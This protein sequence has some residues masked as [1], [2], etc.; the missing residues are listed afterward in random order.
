MSFE[1]DLVFT[2]PTRRPSTYTAS[3]PVLLWRAT[4]MPTAE[5]VKRSLSEACREPDASTFPFIAPL[6]RSR[7]HLPDRFTLLLLSS[8]NVGRNLRWLDIALATRA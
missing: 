6:T 2:V 1:P 4:T 5:P 3:L 8:T 7:L